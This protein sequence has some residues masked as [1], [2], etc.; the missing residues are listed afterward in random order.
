MLPSTKL[1][2]ETAK[3]RRIKISILEDT[4]AFTLR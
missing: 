3:S 1:A 4:Y 2:Y